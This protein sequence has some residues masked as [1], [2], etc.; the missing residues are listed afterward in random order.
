MI[1]KECK[2]AG[3]DNGNGELFCNVNP[4]TAAIIMAPTV[5]GNRPAVMSIRPTVTGDDVGCGVG[6]I[7]L[8]PD[9]HR[10]LKEIKKR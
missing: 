1:C 6:E 5:G 2:Y 10:H 3:A 9:H 8:R 4:P 7:D